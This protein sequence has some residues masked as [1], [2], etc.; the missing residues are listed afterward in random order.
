MA[1]SAVLDQIMTFGQV[2]DAL[3][4]QLHRLQ[5]M[6]DRGDVVVR[7]KVGRHRVVYAE[8]LPAIRAA[9]VR[10]GYLASEG[11]RA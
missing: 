6:A 1:P 2:A 10:C 7:G 8:D 3:R 11:D 4:L 5:R 9:A